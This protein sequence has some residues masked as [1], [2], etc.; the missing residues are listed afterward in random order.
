MEVYKIQNGAYPTTVSE[1]KSIGFRFNQDAFQASSSSP[2]VINLFYCR[3]DN[4]EGYVLQS[5]T[6]NGTKLFVSSKSAN[7]REYTGTDSYLIGDWSDSCRTHATN[8]PGTS[9]VEPDFEE[10]T[11]YTSGSLTGQTGIGTPDYAAAM[12]YWNTD[13]RDPDWHAWTTGGN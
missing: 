4:D 13:R 8:D 9:V 11:N 1:M 2:A 6:A 12:G 7:P 10:F 5:F 3:Y